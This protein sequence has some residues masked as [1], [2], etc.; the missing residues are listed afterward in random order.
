M[1]SP[2]TG[3][4]FMFCGNYPGKNTTITFK[5][6]TV[7]N[8]PTTAML[9]RDF[10]DVV[11]GETFYQKFVTGNAQ[12][13][14]QPTKS[15]VADHTTIKRMSDIP[16]SGR[17]KDPYPT[18][19]YSTDD[20]AISGYFMNVPGFE[21]VA[22]LT[23]RSF[24]PVDIRSFQSNLTE[25]LHICVLHGKEHLILDI[26]S[27]GGGNIG[28][29]YDVFKQLFPDTEPYAAGN[30]RSHDQLS[31]MGEFF[32]QRAHDVLRDTG[33]IQNYTAVGGYSFF[34][35]RAFNNSSGQ[36][37]DSWD[38]F[39]GPILR[40]GDNFTNLALL[41]IENTDYENYLSGITFN[42]PP[43]QPFLRENIIILA[44]GDCASTCDTFM[45]LM[46]WQGR[47]KTIVGGGRPNPG[48]MQFV[49]G[50]KARR[51]L[52]IGYLVYMV[53]QFY[54]I[55]PKEIQEKANQTKLKEVFESGDYLAHRSDGSFSL[56]LGNGIVKDDA[57]LTPLQ[58]VYEAA[59]C[60][61]WWRPEYFFDIT[62]LW[63]LVAGTAFGLNNTEKWAACVEGST[64]HPSS[65]TGG[66]R[67]VSDSA[68][69]I[70]NETSQPGS[71]GASS[72][73][74]SN[75]SAVGKA[76]PQGGGSKNS[77]NTIAHSMAFWFTALIFGSII[78]ML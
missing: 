40:H 41:D 64:N 51:K 27:N 44:D 36:K 12:K 33:S 30:L 60:R 24:S 66:G 78:N 21:S 29:G 2:A 54:T 50:V 47:V 22:V 70:A 18:P 5:N 77:A 61:F 56:N 37:F 39:N 25:F 31:V 46:K 7:M 55:A 59:D 72:T 38:K 1:K 11:D 32:T 74:K 16:A 53:Q 14:Q 52:S 3:G 10:T 20:Y 71:E 68:P 67:L 69:A 63:A 13:Q 65:V 73:D 15:A 43:I 6:G 9:L 48:P 19:L 17:I 49:G 23:L 75:Q 76:E 42:E 4:G 62:H 35:A 45:H 28:L 34:D 58:F 26:Q 57:T 8:Y